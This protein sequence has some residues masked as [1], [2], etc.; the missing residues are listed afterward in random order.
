MILAILA[1]GL[2]SLILACSLLECHEHHARLD[3]AKRDLT[4]STPYKAANK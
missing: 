3:R 2:P 4:R 1:L